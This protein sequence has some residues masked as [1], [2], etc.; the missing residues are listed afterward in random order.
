M[1]G[2]VNK[3]N[4]KNKKKSRSEVTT[5]LLRSQRGGVRYWLLYGVTT[6]KGNE[7]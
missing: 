6:R 2:Y 5:P 7:D 1:T 3:K 4:F